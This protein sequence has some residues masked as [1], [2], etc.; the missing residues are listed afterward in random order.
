MTRI[1]LPAGLAVLTAVGC[2]KSLHTAASTPEP[3]LRNGHPVVHIAPVET[4][5]FE[6]GYAAGFDYGKSVATPHSAI[7]SD[8]EARQAARQHDAS[9]P[10]E[11]WERGFAEGY[12]DA[13]RN[14][15]TGRK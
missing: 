6:D 1:L 9:Q 10:I 15:V 11:R 5:P 2:G 14:V 8:D 7:P 4:R 12:A 3:E 13:V